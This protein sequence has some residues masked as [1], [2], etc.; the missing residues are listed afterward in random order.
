MAYLKPDGAARPLRDA[1]EQSLLRTG[2]NPER[3]APEL[4]RAVAVADR[5]GV[6][7]WL[8]AGTWWGH[9][10]TAGR[11]GRIGEHFAARDSAGPSFAQSVLIGGR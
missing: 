8:L 2:F 6:V 7:V 3:A 4:E 9:G 1:G 10:I 5:L 11:F